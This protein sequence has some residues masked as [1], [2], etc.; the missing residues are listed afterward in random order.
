MIFA[1]EGKKPIDILRRPG[2]S[3]EGSTLGIS[4]RFTIPAQVMIE[5]TTL[6]G[7]SRALRLQG[8]NKA[9][10]GHRLQEAEEVEALEEG[11]APSLGDCSVYSV[12]RIKDIKQ[13]RAKSRSRNKKR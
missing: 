12:G 13:G 4:G 2:A 6:K 8:R 10:T 3:E 1:R 9:L 7:I 5:E 11:S